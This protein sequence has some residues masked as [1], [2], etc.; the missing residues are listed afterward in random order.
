MVTSDGKGGTE[1]QV[2]VLKRN[3]AGY[4]YFISNNGAGITCHLSW[5]FVVENQS[6]PTRQMDVPAQL[7]A[8]E[9]YL[10]PEV[11]IPFWYGSWM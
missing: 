2:A 8:E 10:L 9:R 3:E 6:S 7:A 5:P 4:A 11:W 1:D